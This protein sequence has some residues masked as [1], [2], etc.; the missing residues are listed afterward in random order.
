MK[1]TLPT[2]W[3]LVMVSTA[4]TESTPGG[5]ARPVSSA[6]RAISLVHPHTV[7]LAGRTQVRS[8]I[9]NELTT[10]VQARN[11]EIGGETTRHRK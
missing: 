7:T 4:A 10:E 3:L 1:Y 2:Q 11:L 6:T 5:C 9:R 8:P